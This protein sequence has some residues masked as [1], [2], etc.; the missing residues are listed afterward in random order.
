[1]N[2]AR[3]KDEAARL[4][5]AL[6]RCADIDFDGDFAAAAALLERWPA[7]G[8]RC[9]WRPEVVAFANLMERELREN[10]HKGGWKHDAPGA[11]IDHAWV[12]MREFQGALTAYPRD[13]QQYLTNL[14]GEGAD[15]ANMV[16][17]VLDVCGAL[18]LGFTPRVE[19]IAGDETSC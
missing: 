15:I 6:R 8:E 16:M 14:A 7:A 3:D 4:A 19:S 13:T 1:M 17:M 12:E 11:L 18:S 10:D 5:D 9:A 2:L